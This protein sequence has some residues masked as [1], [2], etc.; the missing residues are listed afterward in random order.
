MLKGTALTKRFGRETVLHG[1]DMAVQPGTITAIIGPSG[2]GKSTLLRALSLL[3]P[4]DS[5][6]VEMDGQTYNFPA[7]RARG[8]LPSPW[9]R[10]GVVFQQLF[11]WPHLTLRDN[12]MLPLRLRGRSADGRRVKQLLDTFDLSAAADRYPNETS[13]GQRQRA[14]LIRALALDPS[15]LLLDEITSALDVEHVVR[16][17]EELRQARVRGMGILAV[18][19]L[20]GFARSSADHVIFMEAGKIVEANGADI[21]TNPSTTRLKRFLSLVQTAA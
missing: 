8:D 19:H 21:L 9:P 7:K 1:I 5:G 6:T 12:I 15:Y 16:V 14:A 20:I 11:L 10:I 3:E 13:L 17:I 2:G 4:P 18:T